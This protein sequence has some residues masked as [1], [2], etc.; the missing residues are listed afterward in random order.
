[1]TPRKT[2]AGYWVFDSTI[3]GVGRL[4]LSTPARTKREYQGTWKPLLLRLK[5]EG[6]LDILRAIKRG[7]LSLG[8][9]YALEQQGQLSYALH[10]VLAQQPLG[11]AVDRWL[12]GSAP[13]QAT[14]TRYAGAWSSLYTHT[15]LIRGGPIAQ[16][17]DVPWRALRAQWAR[18][19]SHWKQLR[20]AVSKFLSDTFGKHSPFRL[21]VMQAY[22]DCTPAPRLVTLSPKDFRAILNRIDEGYHALYYTLVITGMRVGEY[23]ACTEFHVQ[24]SMVHVPGTKTRKA[25][26]RVPIHPQYQQVIRD[27]IPCPIS[28]DWMYRVWKRAAAEEG[29]NVTLHDLRHCHGQW[30]HEAGADLHEIQRSYGHDS[31]AQ[32]ADYLSRPM[33]PQDAERLANYL[34][35]VG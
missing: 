3:P 11:I 25:A 17:R 18:S 28:R 5:K 6:Y 27:A 14:R 26:R 20:N 19:D 29:F 32:T 4:V 2:T 7:D 13:A 33:A 30:L 22:P 15:D 21:Q 9:V 34:G 24:G 35:R 1:M 10:H 16:L 23:M 31:P 8:T 12:P